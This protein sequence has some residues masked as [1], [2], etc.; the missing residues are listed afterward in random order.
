M[1]RIC[2]YSITGENKY[3]CW[4]IRPIFLRNAAFQASLLIATVK[5][6]WKTKWLRRIGVRHRNVNRFVAV[7]LVTIFWEH[8]GNDRCLNFLQNV[9]KSR[10]FLIHTRTFFWWFIRPHENRTIRPTDQGISAQQAHTSSI[11]FWYGHTSFAALTRPIKGIIFHFWRNSDTQV[12]SD[13]SW[14]HS[15]VASGGRATCQFCNMGGN[16]SQC[17]VWHQCFCLTYD[18]RTLWQISM[19]YGD[20]N[21]SASIQL[22]DW[23]PSLP[24]HLPNAI[25]FCPRKHSTAVRSRFLP[26]I[27]CSQL[28]L[29]TRW[30]LDEP[31]LCCVGRLAL[32]SPSCWFINSLVVEAALRGGCMEPETY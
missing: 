25:T 14:R 29:I 10:T 17:F 8:S 31:L 22:Q 18:H 7:N 1:T 6:Q 15:S 11:P 5:L 24:S 19:T 3:C 16:V 23:C 13:E 32:N 4:V 28:E 26:H 9:A 21:G 20:H 12:H 2:H 30:S 27:H